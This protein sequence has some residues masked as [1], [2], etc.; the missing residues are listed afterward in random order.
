MKQI[1]FLILLFF[2]QTIHSQSD[3]KN[4]QGKWTFSK[5]SFVTWHNGS[6]II[7]STQMN[8]KI[9]IEIHSSDSVIWNYYEAETIGTLVDENGDYAG[10][11]AGFITETGTGTIIKLENND[12]FELNV[13]VERKDFA[14]DLIEKMNKKFII[15]IDN[16]Y[17]IIENPIEKIKLKM[18][19][20][21]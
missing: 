14:G 2:G 20:K 12:S 16:D 18:H 17:L 21:G 4:F 5:Q 9:T 3:I 19:N 11:E 13:N 1:I 8:N 15:L 10:P 6:G 7:D